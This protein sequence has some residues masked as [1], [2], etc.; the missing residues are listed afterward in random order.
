MMANEEAEEVEEQPAEKKEKVDFD[1]G[2]YYSDSNVW[3][4]NYNYEPVNVEDYH[5]PIKAS[6]HKK[7]GNL[8]ILFQSAA[9]K[10]TWENKISK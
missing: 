6:D 10:A 8:Q 5:Q 1:D 7:F 3:F 2:S 4:N 9:M